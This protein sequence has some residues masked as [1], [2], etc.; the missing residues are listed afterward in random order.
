MATLATAKEKLAR[1]TRTMP[2]NYNE[3]IASFLGTSA[4]TIAGS[5]PGRAYAGAVTRSGFADYWER[6]LKEAFGV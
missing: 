2:G 6:K 3:K 5:I 1:K 4:A